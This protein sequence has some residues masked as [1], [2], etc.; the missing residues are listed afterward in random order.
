MYYHDMKVKII[1]TNSDGTVDLEVQGAITYY[2]QHV[3]PDEISK[4]AS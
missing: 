3:Q 4:D 1:R 2:I